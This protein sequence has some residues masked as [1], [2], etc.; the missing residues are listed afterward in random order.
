VR[1]GIIIL[2]GNNGF[3]SGNGGEV[4]RDFVRVVSSEVTTKNMK[5]WGGGEYFK[6]GL[7]GEVEV[8]RAVCSKAGTEYLISNAGD[9]LHRGIG[10]IANASGGFYMTEG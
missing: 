3:Q 6:I 7:F 9:Y 4:E 1:D 5:A 8:E 2:V 10:I